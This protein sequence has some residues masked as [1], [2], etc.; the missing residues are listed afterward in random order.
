MLVMA[1]G[2]AVTGCKLQLSFSDW[3]LGLYPI[4]TD[5][6]QDQ[7]AVA[8]G[9]GATVVATVIT[10]GVA[11]IRVD[12]IGPTTPA[13]QGSGDQRRQKSFLMHSY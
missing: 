7:G 9:R 8:R 13:K 12:I 4:G 6:E 5:P 11:T 3:M 1:T 10:T 2:E